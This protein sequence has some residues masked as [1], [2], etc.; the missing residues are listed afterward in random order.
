MDELAKAMGE[1]GEYVCMVGFLTTASHNEWADAAIARQKEKY[2][3]MKL[4]D[5]DRVETEDSI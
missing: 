3:N 5:V 4:I 1:E 2:P